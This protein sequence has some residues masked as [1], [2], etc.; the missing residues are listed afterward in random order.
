MIPEDLQLIIDTAKES[1]NEAVAF[2][3]KEFSHIR[4][5]KASPSLLDNVKVNY[6]G[7]QTPAKSAC[8][9]QCTGTTPSHG[10]AV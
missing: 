4:A 6:F 1:M 7:S 8:Q 9:C 2:A 10:S 3:K 5:G